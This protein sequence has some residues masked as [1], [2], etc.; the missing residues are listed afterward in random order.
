MVLYLAIIRR[1]DTSVLYLE[2]CGKR[3]K[4]PPAGPVGIVYVDKDPS[5]LA[6]YTTLPGA[7]ADMRNPPVDALLPGGHPL[8]GDL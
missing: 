7:R 1:C 4:K 5:C 8:G 6:E 2:A 3:K